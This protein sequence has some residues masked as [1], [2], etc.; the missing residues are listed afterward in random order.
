M[1]DARKQ[2]E[3]WAVNHV[4]PEELDFRGYHMA[5]RVWM[6]RNTTMERF[7]KCWCAACKAERQ[8]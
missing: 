8:A 4:P 6:Y 2:F 7:W 3:E 5:D 1:S